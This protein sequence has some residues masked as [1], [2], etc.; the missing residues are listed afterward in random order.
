VSGADD[1]EGATSR[2][3]GEP[4]VF[5]R[6]GDTELA[7]PGAIRT[8]GFHQGSKTGL[9]LV[10]TGALEDN[11]NVYRDPPTSTGENPVPYYVLGTRNR[12]TGA[13]TAVDLSIPHGEPLTSPVTGK[14]KTVQS[15]SL[16]GR[17]PDVLVEIVPD[18]D[19]DHLVRVLHVEGVKVEE[20]DAVEAGTTPLARS[21]RQLPFPSQ[22]DRIA[23]RHP[24]VHV[25]VQ[26]AR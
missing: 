6:A 7:V 26:P 5:A 8:I 9:P 14:V 24:H 3:A 10:P 16:Y 12:G 25:E 17:T 18:A 15:Y 2:D 19:A 13:T 21:A 20:G 23:G 11:L 4:L 22:I 1:A